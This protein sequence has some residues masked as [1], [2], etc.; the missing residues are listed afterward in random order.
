MERMFRRRRTKLPLEEKLEEFKISL[1]E[2]KEDM[3]KIH[4]V[5]NNLNQSCQF[6]F[7]HTFTKDKR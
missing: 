2:Y 5:K 3:T 4:T 7:C 1:S 6:F